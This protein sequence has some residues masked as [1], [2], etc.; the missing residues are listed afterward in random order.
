G[1][2][3]SSSGNY[4]ALPVGTSSGSGNFSSSSGNFFWQ[5]EHITGSGKTTL[6]VG[7]DRTFN[8]QQSSPKLD[9]ASAIKF[10]E[11]NALKSQQ[12]SLPELSP[13]CMTLE[14]MNRLIS[15]PSFDLDADPRVPLILGRSFLKTGHAL[16][17]VYEGELTLRVG[18]EVVIFNLDQTSRY[19]ANYAAMSV[20]QIDLIDVACE[21]YSQEVLGFSGDILLLE[22]FLNDDPSSPPLPPQKVKVIEPT[23][24]KSS[25][26]EPPM[27]KLKDLPP[28]LEYEFLEVDDKLPII[29]PKDLKY[30][31]K[32]A[33]IKVLKSHKQALAWK[34]SDIKCIDPKFYTHKILMEDDFE[35]AVQH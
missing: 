25:I 4:F 21:E 14:L 5:W 33:L 32:T 31:E 26:D 28:H 15:R 17:G 9:V 3:S 18:K 27:V 13:T 16:I 34:L 2:N 23:N 8:S 29:I 11:L 6:E 10:L 30:E 22:E 20:N 24:E 7:M 1:K 12:L 19:S 35:S